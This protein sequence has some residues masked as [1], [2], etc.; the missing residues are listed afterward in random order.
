MGPVDQLISH[1]GDSFFHR[2]QRL[3]HLAALRNC[4]GQKAEE[5][6]DTEAIA[7]S[8]EAGQSGARRRDALFAMALLS[9]RPAAQHPEDV[10]E[11]RE[12]LVLGLLNPQLSDFPARDRITQHDVEMAREITRVRER[13]WL[14]QPF[15][16]RDCRP[17]LRPRRID[18]A[19][20]PLRQSHVALRLEPRLLRHLAM[21]F[22]AVKGYSL[23]KIF[24]RHLESA[25]V[26]N[27]AYQEVASERERSLFFLGTFRQLTDSI[28]E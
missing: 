21:V 19:E 18:H 10:Q 9:Q 6:T 5:R 17:A 14:A 2:R 23:P 8:L 12:R 27:Q 28:S 4:L 26:I 24:A 16:M 22:L 25:P 13:E 7:F 11:Q 1:G 3:C 20:L 15:S